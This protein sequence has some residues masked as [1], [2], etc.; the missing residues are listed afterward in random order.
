M[1]YP[2][3]LNKGD[4]I[5]IICPSSPVDE[6]KTPALIQKMEELGYKVKAAVR[7]LHGRNRQNQRR[8]DKQNV[9]RP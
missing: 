9:R 3:K 2:E 8:V 1:R 6:G 5:G 4:T 7:R